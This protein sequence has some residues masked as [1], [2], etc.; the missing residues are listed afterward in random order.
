[1]D[2]ERHAIEVG[3]RPEAVAPVD[4]LVSHFSR[5]DIFAVSQL[6]SAATAI[7]IAY[8]QLERLPNRSVL[9][10]KLELGKE[11]STLRRLHETA[12]NLAVELNG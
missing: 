5:S 3:S 7:E 6:L 12:I 10:L 8:T 9:A 11:I 2:N 1:M 4:S